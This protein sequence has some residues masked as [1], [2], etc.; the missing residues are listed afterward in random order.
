MPA[1][2]WLAAAAAALTADSTRPVA[3]TPLVFPA[4]AAVT[5]RAVPA[6]TGRPRAVQVSEGYETR[7]RLHRWGSYAI[8][9]LFAGQYV[10]GSRL[11]NQ[12]E[13][14]L[15][16]RRNQP[17]DPDLRRNHAIVAGAVGVVF[18]ANTVTGVWNLVESRGVADGRTRR[19]VHALAMLGAEAGFVATGVLGARATDGTIDDARTHRNVA[20]GSVAV[21]TASVVSMWILNRD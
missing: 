17:I 19:L 7:L 16:G 5:T 14:Q 21:S 9:P 13:D 20:L 10:L 3:P 12:K 1:P 18:V 11:L 2:L 8:L 4:P 6:D 15:A